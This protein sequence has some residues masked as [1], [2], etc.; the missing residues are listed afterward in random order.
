MIL[1]AGGTGTLGREV[2]AR[3]TA[4]GRQ[5]RVLTRDG[6][7]A[8]GLDVD[9]AIGDVR[10]PGTLGA[11]VAGTSA[12]VSAVHGFVGG[13]GAGPDEVDRQ[14][15]TNLV[16][17][18]RAAGVGQFVLLS[19]FDA[20]PD[21]PLSLHRAKY[22]AEQELHASGLPWTVLRPTSYIETWA[23]VIGG[24]VKAGGPAVV[25]GRAEN[26]INFVSVEDV[27]TL[28]AS[29]VADGALRGETVDV[30]GVENLT[31]VQLAEEL[32]AGSVRHVPRGVLRLM[33][34][35]LP[36]FAPAFARQAAAAVA[37]D[38]MDMS[39]DASALCARFP[40]V[41]WHPPSEVARRFRA[42]HDPAAG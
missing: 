41:S 27:A 15:N 21:H 36:L 42:A 25:F 3:L 8:Q 22:A 2:V 28:V 12:V 13:R 4:A 29:S 1:V 26:P 11:A 9:V 18:A 35:V 7:R 33:A 6:A 40:E 20:R 37:M 39:A 31:M 30:P 34:A 38:T 14:G 5:V 32:G 17:A 23:E 19:A 24:K 10:D 16:R